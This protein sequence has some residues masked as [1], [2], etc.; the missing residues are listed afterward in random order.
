VAGKLDG[1]GAAMNQHGVVERVTPC[2]PSFVSSRSGAH[3]VTGPTLASMPL[4]T[5]DG[6]P[7]VGARAVLGSQHIATLDRAE[8]PGKALSILAENKFERFPCLVAAANRGRFAVRRSASLPRLP[9]HSYVRP[10][11]NSWQGSSILAENKFERFNVIPS[12][13]A[14]IL[15]LLMPGLAEAHVGSPNVFFEGNAGPFPVHVI[16]R[17]PEVIPGLAEISV[18]VEGGPVQE[19]TALP[20]KWNA[21]RKGA[22]PPDVARLVR[23]ETNLYTAQLWFME[24]GSQSVELEVKGTSGTGRALIPVDAVA[25]RV[26]PMDKSLGVALAA[27]GMVLGLLLLSVIGAAVRESMLDPGQKPAP[28]RKWMARGAVTVGGGLLLLAVWGGK[29]WWDAEAADYRN[30]R[31]YQPMSAQATVQS[32][33]GHR[34]LRLEITDPRFERA[35]PLMPD[36]G[37]LM[38]L[39]LVQEPKLETFAHL[40]PI[41]LDRKTF[42]VG[43]PDLPEGQY[44]IYA[45]VTYETGF[46]DTLTTSFKLPP[47]NTFLGGSSNGPDPD[48]TW[49]TTWPLG[50]K[51]G[52][53]EC[54]LS[55]NYTMKSSAQKSYLVN[56]PAHLTFSVL[57]KNGDPVILEPYLGMRGHL[58]LRRDDGSVFTHLHPGGTPSMASIQLSALRAEGKLPLEAAFGKN[59]PICRL[60]VL[61]TAQQEW[62]KGSA[63]TNESSVTFPYAF[64]KPGRYRLWVQVKIKGE[65]LTGVYDVEALRDGQ[66]QA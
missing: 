13:L 15:F 64:P 55:Q 4:R 41:K 45:D 17:P 34:I 31:L 51:P 16:I 12:I 39:F 48:D 36:H 19:V 28:R 47:A 10:R 29:H 5:E 46:S 44:R 32:E 27:L 1:E 33:A 54:E 40:H 56:K 65:I 52:N 25:I 35:S 6:S 7:S 43:L 59:D 18:R 14:S 20:I 3:R 63:A 53:A 11:R 24:S 60:P 26:L 21:G 38:H 66:P 49:R 22:P 57:S 9:A 23:G 58:A 30:N 61:S 50:D 42:E 2:G 8:I 37:K 62:L